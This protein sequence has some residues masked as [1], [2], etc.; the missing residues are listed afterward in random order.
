MPSLGTRTVVG[1]THNSLALENVLC[2][3]LARGGYR[4]SPS[5]QSRH[6]CTRI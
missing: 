5:R 1:V 6:M 3:A 2:V 4:H